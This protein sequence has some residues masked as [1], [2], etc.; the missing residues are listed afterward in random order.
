MTDQRFLALTTMHQHHTLIKK[1]VDMI[2]ETRFSAAEEREYRETA[3]E[4]LE[5][6]K[7]RLRRLVELMNAEDLM[8][9]IKHDLEDGIR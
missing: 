1:L 9:T 3:E 6:W 4:E 7:F 5:R 2:R 8:S